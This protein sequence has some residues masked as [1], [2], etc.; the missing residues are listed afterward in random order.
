MPRKNPRSTSMKSGSNFSAPAAVKEARG[1][2][3][4]P[5]PTATTT[6]IVNGSAPGS[7]GRA[8]SNANARANVNAAPRQMQ[9][10]SKP[11]SS[12]RANKNADARARANVITPPPSKPGSSGRAASNANARANVNAAPPKMQ[13][14]S[15]Q[16]R[17]KKNESV[18]KKNAS[19]GAG[20]K[21]IDTS[22]KAVTSKPTLTP[23]TSMPSNKPANT[24]PPRAANTVPPRAAKPAAA[25][26][27]APMA[28][29]LQSK[30]SPRAAGFKPSAN[31]TPTVGGA[32]K[33]KE[34]YKPKAA[35]HGRR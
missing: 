14:L 32:K 19:V 28:K 10:P 25:P 9:T 23:P 16:N 21:N 30:S 12:G 13:T 24:V 8:A 26:A 7:S 6:A 35:W 15:Q 22:N 11:G 5:K 27:A 4:K 31:R 20:S 1:Y 33:H 29:P 17:D 18:V 3:R 34:A 2:G